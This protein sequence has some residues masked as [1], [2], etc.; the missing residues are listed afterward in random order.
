MD[1][2]LVKLGAL[3]AGAI[4]TPLVK[5][6]IL[7]WA[8]EISREP[9]KLDERYDGV[10]E[11]PIVGNHRISLRPKKV[12]NRVTGILVFLEGIHAGKDY[13]ISG[14]YSHGLLT[15]TYRPTDKRSTSSG[16]G[17]FQR[18][19]DGTLLSGFFSYISQTSNR[20]QSIS[21]DLRPVR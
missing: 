7:P 6:I 15:F 2:S 20:V 9:T 14:R 5:D 13:K 16:S 10:L 17:T 12:G 19:E 8:T 3:V 4:A 1:D 11:W 21:C 18:L